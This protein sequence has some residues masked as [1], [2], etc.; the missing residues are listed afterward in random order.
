MA[1]PFPLCSGSEGTA[2]FT[3]AKNPS[4]LMGEGL[5]GGDASQTVRPWCRGLH[6]D[7]VTTSAFRECGW[8][9]RGEMHRSRDHTHPPPPPPPV[10]G[11]GPKNAPDHLTKKFT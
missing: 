5:G 7:F 11:G 6:R 4:P 8:L 3:S 1:A 2:L 10:G 9:G